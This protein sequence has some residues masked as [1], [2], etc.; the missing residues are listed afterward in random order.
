[1]CLTTIIRSGN[2]RGLFRNRDFVANEAIHTKKD[3]A[4]KIFLET[5]KKYLRLRAGPRRRL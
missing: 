4:K 1:M 2:T 3:F 5:P